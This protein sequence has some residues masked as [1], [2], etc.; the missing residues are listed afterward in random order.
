MELLS[1]LLLCLLLLLSIALIGLTCI[2]ESL[3]D[4]A[5]AIARRLVKPGPPL[6]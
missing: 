2:G 6:G 4:S 5:S 1:R 3:F